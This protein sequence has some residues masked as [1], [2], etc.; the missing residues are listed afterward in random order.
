MPTPSQI[1]EQVRLERDQIKQGINLLRDNTEGLE[2]KSYSSA[3]LYGITS[4]RELLPLVI[5]EIESCKKKL[6]QGHNGVA[7]KEVYKYFENVDSGILAAITC[8]VLIDKVFSTSYKSNYLIN[9]SFSMCSS[10]ED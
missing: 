10:L 4:I 3:S 5:E 7:F 6:K 1:D 9:I 8:K 2:Q